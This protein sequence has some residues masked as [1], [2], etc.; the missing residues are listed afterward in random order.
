M[1]G[2]VAQ[3]L[4]KSNLLRN[5]P[6]HDPV[7][8]ILP[9]YLPPSYDTCSTEYPCVICLAGFT[10]S[11]RSWFNFQAWI[12]S[13]DER[14]DRL[15]A[16][17]M[18]E[19]IL[20]FPDC[21]TRYGGSQYL[22]SIAVGAYRSYLIE[23]II[24]FV[25]QRYRVKRDR[26]FRGVMGKSSGGYGAI[27]IA[28]DHPQLF[29][30]TA[31]HSGDMYFE[32]AYTQEFPSAQR[33]LEK[34]GGLSRFLERFDELPKAGKDDHAVLDLIAMSACYSPNPD[35]VPHRFDLPFEEWSG[36]IR[37][38][39]WARWKKHDP[40]EI[41]KQ[42]GESLREFGLVYVDCGRRDEFALNLGARMFCAELAGQGIAHQYE[43]FDDG[44]FNIQYRYDVSLRKMAE[45]F[46]RSG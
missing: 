15:I 37:E 41:V 20:V 33:K 39:V 10:G 28:M 18:P 40:L 12:P 6:L 5:N 11:G 16:N 31:C 23:E 7:D 4:L 34:A 45:Y 14:M 19:M 36:R 30:A 29:S 8:R 24:P 1:K 25:E 21:F 2:R 38:D 46:Q 9:V 43:E 22:D 17:G 42:K 35:A 27:R 32:Y 26:R 44:H 13:I 3:E